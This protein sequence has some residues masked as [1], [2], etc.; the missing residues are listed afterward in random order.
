MEV[1]GEWLKMEVEV[2]EKKEKKK[3]LC[4]VRIETIEEVKRI[5]D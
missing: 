2:T 3:E 5:M 4:L 1:D